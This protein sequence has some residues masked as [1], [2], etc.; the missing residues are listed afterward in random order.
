MRTHF[1]V[2]GAVLGV[3]ALSGCFTV[4]LPSNDP[5]S[6]INCLASVSPS[7]SGTTQGD[8]AFSVGSSYQSTAQT[9][10]PDAGITG[11]TMYI[12]LLRQAVPCAQEPDA[13]DTTSE[14]VW[15][16]VQRTGSDRVTAGTYA[17][18]QHTD[19]GPFFTGFAVLDGGVRVLQEGSLTLSS[20]ADC[21]A[22][23]TFSATFGVGDGGT[24]SLSGTFNSDYC[25]RR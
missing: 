23:G 11:A 25:V 13:G 21:S 24:S 18:S 15:F 12:S 4:P 5:D 22:A 19:G 9:R 10:P 6:G 14:G 8:L 3:S 7:G 17:D 2:A 16:W 20:V 1:L